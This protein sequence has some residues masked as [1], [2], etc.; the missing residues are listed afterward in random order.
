MHINPGPHVAI[1]KFERD[2]SSAFFARHLS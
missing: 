1:P 2:A